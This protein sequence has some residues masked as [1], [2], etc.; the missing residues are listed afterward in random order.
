MNTFTNYG[1]ILLQQHE[2]KRQIA[3]ALAGNMRVLVR[4]LG[5]LL[6]AVCRHE[7]GASSRG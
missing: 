2:G 3:S 7:S 4:R 6:M 1:E 5:K